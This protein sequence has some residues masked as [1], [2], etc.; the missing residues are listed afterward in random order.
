VRA[1]REGRVLMVDEADKAPVEVVGI[2]KGN[3]SVPIGRRRRRSPPRDLCLPLAGLS[4]PVTRLSVPLAG[5]SVPVTQLSVPLAGLSVPL[6]GLSV[7]V[8]IIRTL[9]GHSP[10]RHLCIPLAGLSVPLTRLFVPLA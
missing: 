2:L 3:R 9:V 5:F 8:M 1:V 7:H 6:A 4:V 10:L